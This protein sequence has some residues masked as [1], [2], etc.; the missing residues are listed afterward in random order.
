MRERWVDF[1]GWEGERGKGVILQKGMTQVQILRDHIR[2]TQKKWVDDG[3]AGECH[4]E[5]ESGGLMS[6][7]GC[8]R[9]GRKG[10]PFRLPAATHVPLPFTPGQD[11]P[12]PVFSADIKK[13]FHKGLALDSPVV[14]HTSPPLTPG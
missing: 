10:L 11:A 3:W 4:A 9:V 8:G 7:C 12:T 13:L 6:F 5:R 2:L 14:T 1:G